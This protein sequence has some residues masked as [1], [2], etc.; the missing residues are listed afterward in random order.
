MFVH[1][2]NGQ[3][4]PAVK[5]GDIGVSKLTPGV[6]TSVNREGKLFRMLTKESHDALPAAPPVPWDEGNVRGETM[7]PHG[8]EQIL[9][10][11]KSV[12]RFEQRVIDDKA[13]GMHLRLPRRFL[14]RPPDVHNGR[15]RCKPRV[16]DVKAPVTYL[17]LDIND[18]RRGYDEKWNALVKNLQKNNFIICRD[19]SGDARFI[20]SADNRPFRLSGTRREAKAVHRRAQLAHSIGDTPFRSSRRPGHSDSRAWREQADKFLQGFAFATGVD[21]TGMYA[22]L[23]S[24][25]SLRRL[26]QLLQQDEK[27]IGGSK[28]PVLTGSCH[29]R[30]DEIRR[31][32][33]FRLDAEEVQQPRQPDRVIGGAGT[34][35][36]P[37]AFV[38]GLRRVSLNS[39]GN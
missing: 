10:V 20:S 25:S 34:R 3:L 9:V 28:D 35:K 11:D 24:L 5:L 33:R 38:H 1:A 22:L 23:P 14:E 32:A 37:S 26:P 18:R 19:Y 8:L 29:G 30:R 6:I 13:R 27:V 16:P 4:Q 31:R 39:F 7:L 15:K 17:R 21:E 2:L 36:D 12:L